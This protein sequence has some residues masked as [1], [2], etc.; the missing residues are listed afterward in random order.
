MA[1][2]SHLVSPAR[3]GPQKIPRPSGTR[4]GDAAPWAHTP[5]AVRTGFTL[6]R[7]RAALDGLGPPRRPELVVA[8][9]VPA[10]VLVA[11]FE[12]GGETRVVLTRRTTTLPSHRGEVSFPGG[13]AH[14]GEDLRSAAL[15]EAQEELDLRPDAIEVVGELDHLTTVASRFVLAPFAGLL[16]GRPALTPNPREVDRAFDVTLAELMEDDVFH[17]ER[18]EILGE[19]RPVFFFDLVGD[20][21]WGATARI[22]HQLLALLTVG[23]VANDA[24]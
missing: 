9:A 17:E 4:A 12:E 23:N 6:E 10:A 5:A 2:S 1:V 7:V 19:E 15:R 8:G 21:V 11:L 16:A 13:K 3:G 14:D 18:W 20:T 24:L 22:L